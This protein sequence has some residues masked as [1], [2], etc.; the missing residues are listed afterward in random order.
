MRLFII[1]HG[2]TIFNEQDRIQGNIES[3]FSEN[4]RKQV[5][6][7]AKAL[8]NLKLDAVYSSKRGRALKTA[9]AIAGRHNLPVS[10]DDA[11]NERYYGIYEGRPVGDMKVE[12]SEFFAREPPL[13]LDAKPE[14]GESINEVAAR[15]LPFVDKIAAEGHGTCILV[16]HGIVNKIILAHLIDGDISQ[17]YKYRQFNACINELELDSKGKG[18]TKV[19][20]IRLNDTSHLSDGN[21]K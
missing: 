11:I 2:E 3:P 14:G 9:Q 7:L 12:H 21:F 5:E 20:V 1:R 4:G 17:S 19:R 18:K 13:D 16:A 6:L 8:A 10:S 15:A